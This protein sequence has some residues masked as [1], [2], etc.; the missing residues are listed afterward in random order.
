[1]PPS[2]ARLSARKRRDLDSLR[3]DPEIENAICKAL[4]ELFAFHQHSLR[5][6]RFILG[7]ASLILADAM[8]HHI[9]D[10][11]EQLLLERDRNVPP[12]VSGISPTTTRFPVNQSRSSQTSTSSGVV[13]QRILSKAAPASAASKSAK[14]SPARAERETSRS[15][16]AS[17]SPVNARSSSHSISRK[18]IAHQPVASDVS[19]QQ[20]SN[21]YD[22]VHNPPTSDT[23]SSSPNVAISGLRTCEGSHDSASPGTPPKES[24]T[25]H[26]ASAASMPKFCEVH[27]QTSIPAKKRK[28]YDIARSVNATFALG[29]ATAT[30]EITRLSKNTDAVGDTDADASTPKSTPSQEGSNCSNI[31]LVGDD[32]QADTEN[33]SSASEQ[34]GDEN[35]IFPDQEPTPYDEPVKTHQAQSPATDIQGETGTTLRQVV[36]ASPSKTDTARAVESE[37]DDEMHQ[38]HKDF[39][40]EVPRMHSLPLCDFQSCSSSYL[41]EF[42]CA[43]TWACVSDEVSSTQPVVYNRSGYTFKNPTFQIAVANV[44]RMIDSARE[45]TKCV[46]EWS[47]ELVDMLQERPKICW[48]SIQY[49]PSF[50]QFVGCEVCCQYSEAKHYLWACGTRYDAKSFW[51]TPCQFEI[52]SSEEVS[53]NTTRVSVTVQD[54]QGGPP[55]IPLFVDEHMPGCSIDS[56]AEDTEE[57]WVDLRCMWRCLLYHELTHIVAKMSYVIKQR[58]LQV[59]RRGQVD[60]PSPSSNPHRKTRASDALKTTQTMSRVKAF[61]VDTVLSDSK[62]VRDVT[63][64]L[65]DLHTCALLYK[66]NDSD[67]AADRVAELGDL[68][69][70]TNMPAKLFL[71]CEVKT[72]GWISSICRTFQVSSETSKDQLNLRYMVDLLTAI[73]EEDSTVPSY[74]CDGKADFEH[75]QHVRDADNS[76]SQVKKESI[77]EVD[78]ACLSTK[79]AA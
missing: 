12:D 70:R 2:G 20:L 17:S 58:V 72:S 69:L 43:M 21:P 44:L 75:E 68:V 39:N 47:P 73:S 29:H 54:N 19:S 55:V 60:I 41:R 78:V 3:R 24:S 7:S 77:P 6:Q 32:N 26:L 23:T 52:I 40:Y 34:S 38:W 64:W 10:A 13:R 50:R 31:Q 49:H 65:E 25:Q 48:Q 15:S 45:A 36:S 79:P 9:R 57:F 28:L 18:S 76:I 8:F 59:L 66:P 11:T 67:A 1:M 35:E 27:E 30:A 16:H 53:E 56:L 33:S 37:T 63:D 51:P 42:I 5:D 62:F 74:L 46:A 14:L 4:N 22:S 71:N 61:L